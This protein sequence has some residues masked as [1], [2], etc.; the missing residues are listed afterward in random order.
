MT[1][2][3]PTMRY[4]TCGTVNSVEAEEN[5]AHCLSV[6]RN[7]NRGKSRSLCDLSQHTE[8]R[9]NTEYR[10]LLKTTE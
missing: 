9:K 10:V 1:I 7:E 6:G 4:V 5:R 8:V 3:Y 2:C